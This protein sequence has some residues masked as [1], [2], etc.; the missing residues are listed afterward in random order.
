MKKKLEFISIL[1]R[2]ILTVNILRH[3]IVLTLMHFFGFQTSNGGCVHLLP[4]LII[5]TS[6]SGARCYEQ[7]SPKV[8]FYR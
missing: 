3:A 7:V 6:H 8:P 5:P 1:T 4:A 2:F